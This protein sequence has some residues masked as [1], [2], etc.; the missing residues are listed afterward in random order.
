[1]TKEL[2]GYEEGGVFEFQDD[3]DNN[4]RTLTFHK[5]D[6][7]VFYDVNG[8]IVQILKYCHKT[9]SG[10]RAGCCEYKFISKGEKKTMEN[11][12]YKVLSKDY[13]SVFGGDGGVIAYGFN[14]V[15]YPKVSGTYLF[16]FDDLDLAKKYAKDN[17]AIVCEC[18]VEGLLEKNII[19]KH[20][21]DKGFDMNAFPKG[22]RFAYGVTLTKEIEEENRYAVKGKKWYFVNGYSN[23]VEIWEEVGDGTAKRLDVDQEVTFKITKDKIGDYP[24]NQMTSGG[25]YVTNC[26]NEWKVLTKLLRDKV[27]RP[28]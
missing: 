20:L 14:R 12:F 13:T 4:K 2:F 18:E 6:Y 19:P 21:S 5:D 28:C 17:N 24:L 23:A 25:W 26:E 10:L 11:K 16:I 15:T 27:V 9:E 8:C 3:G 7:W 1:M 22:T